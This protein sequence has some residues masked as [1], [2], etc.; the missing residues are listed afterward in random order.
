MDTRDKREEA[1]RILAGELIDQVVHEAKRSGNAPAFICEIMKLCVSYVERRFDREAPELRFPQ[2]P[3]AHYFN[4][5]ARQ[6]E[7]SVLFDEHP[8]VVALV[9]ERL[10]PTFREFAKNAQRELQAAD[11]RRRRDDA[12][13]TVRFKVT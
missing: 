12:A 13:R 2:T 5:L 4:N 6:V 7:E 9:L 10:M 3:S 1:H 11:I 8:I